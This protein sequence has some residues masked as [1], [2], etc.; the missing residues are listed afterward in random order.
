[1]PDFPPGHIYSGE[2]NDAL[3]WRYSLRCRVEQ[4]EDKA[5]YLPQLS[6]LNERLLPVVDGWQDL[7]LCSD[8]AL[9]RMIGKPDE[10]GSFRSTYRKA[11]LG[12]LQQWN[13]EKIEKIAT[14]WL[15]KNAHLIDKF[16]NAGRLSARFF[17]P[18]GRECVH[19]FQTEMFG[20][21][22]R[23]KQSGSIDYQSMPHD[24]WLRIGGY[25]HQH[26]SSLAHPINQ[27]LDISIWQGVMAEADA[28][29]LAIEIGG[30]TGARKI[31]KATSGFKGVAFDDPVD[32]Y[33]KVRYSVADQFEDAV[34][35]CNRFGSL[36]VDLMSKNP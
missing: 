15:T 32:G 30:M 26:N 3:Y 29:G 25:D 5:Y 33:H 31:W 8:Q 2:P 22:R 12:G 1:M 7:R 18:K 11:P 35:G 4:E 36:W 19:F 34:A 10:N 20:L 14:R 16:E 6:V 28:D 9:Q 13:A 21:L 17:E 24:F 23:L 27:A